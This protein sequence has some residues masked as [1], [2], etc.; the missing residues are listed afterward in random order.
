MKRT[1]FYLS[2]LFSAYSVSAQTFKSEVVSTAGTIV[3]LESEIYISTTDSVMTIKSLKSNKVFKYT[4]VKIV[5]STY[6]K[7]SDGMQDY[8]VR[9]M[10]YDEPTK[11]LGKK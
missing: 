3:K 8:V 7:I 9:V 5:D 4:I 11:I 6:F 10:K 2:F 1:L